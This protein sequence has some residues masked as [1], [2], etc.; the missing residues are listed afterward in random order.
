ME[1]IGFY[2]I[3]VS[4]DKKKI[5]RLKADM[6]TKGYIQIFFLSFFS[7]FFTFVANM[8]Y[9]RPFLSM[10]IMRYW[11]L[12]QLDMNNVLLN[13]DLEEEV[14]LEEPSGFVA[15]RECRG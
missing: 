4:I 13:R 11:S 15:V 3:K 8:T 2:T 9:A 14:Y 1:V 10:V 5:V 7:A 6:M 12:Y